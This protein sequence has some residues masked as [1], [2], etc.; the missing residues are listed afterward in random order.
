MTRDETI[1][2][3]DNAKLKFARRVRDGKESDL[4]FIEGVRL[5][6]EAVRSGIEITEVFVA[7]TASAL[8]KASSIIGKRFEASK[9]AAKA[10]DSITDTEN[11]QGIVILARRPET[12]ETVDFSAGIVV[13]LHEINNP[14]NL[15]AIIRTAE[16]AGVSAVIISVGSTDAFSPKTIRSSMGSCFRLPIIEGM[17]FDAA[18]DLAIEHK[19]IATAADIGAKRSYLEVDWNRPRLLIFGSEAHGLSEIELSKVERPISI[20]MA[21]SVESLNLAVS[22]GIIL[23]EAKRQR[24]EFGL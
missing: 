3:R 16:A 21:D 15:G 19:L 8:E 24:A 4:I 5:A 9:V 17:T 10:F 11:S 2:S 1:T 7:D 12:L 20:P 14:S 22:A 13:F 6:E 23:F 18:L